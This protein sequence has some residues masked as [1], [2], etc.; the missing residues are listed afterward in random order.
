MS[1]VMFRAKVRGIYSTALTKILLDNGFRIVQPS[2]VTRTRFNLQETPEDYNQPDIEVFDRLDKQGV[3]IVGRA[4][5]ANKLASTLLSLLDDVVIRRHIQVYKAAQLAGE[6]TQLGQNRILYETIMEVISASPD[7]RIRIDVEFPALSK[8]K[9]DEIRSA[10]TPTIS[11]HHYYK[12]CGGKVAGMLE[13]AEKLIEKGYSHKEAEELLREC[14]IREYPS[15]TS[16]ICIEHVK[17]SGRIFNLGEARVAEF[18]EREQRMTL[19]RTFSSHGVYDGLNV[20]KEPGDYAVTTLR[21]GDWFLK[22]SY[23]SKG[24]EYKGTYINISTPIELY[25]MKIRYIDLEAD[26]CMWP[27]GRV[28]KIDFEKLDDYVR[29]GYVSEKLRR[30]VYEKVEEIIDT[31]SVNVEME[32]KNYLFGS[33]KLT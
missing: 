20:L 24:G 6:D 23:F 13:M 17:I 9:L 28:Q 5:A 27:D 15:E 22:T 11:G 2:E 25:P 19:I 7:V 4:D 8:R 29:M 21:I 1:S 14:V 18:N 3:N 10:V 30:L 26:I 32:A 31:L 33:S 16:K 12:A